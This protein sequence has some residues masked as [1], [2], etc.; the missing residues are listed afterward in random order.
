MEREI[1]KRIVG[2]DEVVNKVLSTIKRSLVG[3]SN[4]DKPIASFLFIGP[5]GVGK[6][7]LAKVI[8]EKLF[9]SKTSLIKIDMSEL[10][11]SHSISKL[12]GSPPGYV[13]YEEGGSLTEKVKRQPY[14]VILFDEVEKASNNILNILLQILDE[15]KVTDA[16][17][18][19]INFKNTLIILTSN[20][21]ITSRKQEKIGFLKKDTIDDRLNDGVSI[22]SSLQKYFSP[23]FLNRLDDVVVFNKLDKKVLVKI[24][25]L[26]L[27]TIIKRLEYSG[28]KLDIEEKVLE[29]IL[30][31][32]YNE[33]FG[34]REIKRLL[35]EQ[36]LNPLSEQII[37]KKKKEGV[38]EVKLKNNKV[39]FLFK[40][41]LEHEKIK[42]LA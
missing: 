40:S 1:Q 32:N 7:E 39:V 38:W 15:G 36:I 29:F 18:Q 26:E 4:P 25:N 35:N 13:G 22:L 12:I 19:E 33:D 42:V 24:A 31:N 41:S 11:E 5:T 8:A 23:E 3:I 16:H 10:M 28:I 17:G 6:T 14:S 37:K 34:A 2:Q 21:E 27:E 9:L 20:I 30:E